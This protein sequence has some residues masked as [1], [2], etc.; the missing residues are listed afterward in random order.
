MYQLAQVS[1]RNNGVFVH[2]LNHTNSKDSRFPKIILEGL[3]QRDREALI[4]SWEAKSKAESVQSFKSGLYGTVGVLACGV[5]LCL[6]IDFFILNS[7]ASYFAFQYFNAQGQMVYRLALPL[8][9]MITSHAVIGF[10]GGLGMIGSGAYAIF[11]K[12]IKHHFVKAKEHAEKESHI[13]KELF[14]AVHPE[15]RIAQPVQAHQVKTEEATV[16][17]LSKEELEKKRRIDLLKTALYVACAGLAVAGTLVL[18]YLTANLLLFVLIKVTFFEISSK[19]GYF[20]LHRHPIEVV[21]S[22]LLT[23]EFMALA[24]LALY[25]GKFSVEKLRGMAKDSFN[26]ATTGYAAGLARLKK[27]KEIALKFERLS[28]AVAAENGNLEGIRPDGSVEAETDSQ[29]G[30][31]QQEAVRG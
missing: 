10:G 16:K 12:L 2:D 1:D 31:I 13:E 26:Q 5:L 3:S 4:K 28:L 9:Q 21:L 7:V 23:T 11:D 17:A 20:I 29:P 24:G 18:C 30:L 27:E 14:K 19:L 8:S 22:V 15:I 6:V 25:Y